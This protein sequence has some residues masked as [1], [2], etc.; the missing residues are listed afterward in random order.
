[1]SYP[2]PP[3]DQSG[4]GYQPMPPQDHPRAMLALILGILGLVVCSVLAPFAWSIGRTAVRE[5]DASGGRYGGRGAAQAGYVLGVI[6]TV[7]LILG[8]LFFAVVAVIV[9][10]GSVSSTT[11]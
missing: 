9:V 3:P 10:V 8:V 4:A 5:I 6:G 2:P 1:M 7:I 11:G